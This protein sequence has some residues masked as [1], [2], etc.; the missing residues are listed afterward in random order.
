MDQWA[1]SGHSM[2]RLCE[3]REIKYLRTAGA[4]TLYGLCT[5]VGIW[6]NG[7]LQEPWQVNA[8]AAHELG[9]WHLHQGE[10]LLLDRVSDWVVLAKKEREAWEWARDL[11]VPQAWLYQHLDEPMEMLA[12]ER[13]V[14]EAFLSKCFAS[15]QGRPDARNWLE[16]L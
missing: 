12:E 8:V 10:V 11:L 7:A 9:H 16:C 6:V 2:S 14:S 13:Q 1:A 4:P 3:Q 15:Y 5:R